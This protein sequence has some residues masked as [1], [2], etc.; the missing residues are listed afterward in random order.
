M[1]SLVLKNVTFSQVY[2][3]C[4]FVKSHKLGITTKLKGHNKVLATYLR[5]A[6]AAVIGHFK[7]CLP[8]D[9]CLVGILRWKRRVVI[10]ESAALRLALEYLKLSTEK[11]ICLYSSWDESELRPVLERMQGINEEINR[12]IATIITSI[13]NRDEVALIFADWLEERGDLFG[14]CIRLVIADRPEYSKRLVQL[15]RELGI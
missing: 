8:W 5:Y 15:W 10:F 11:Y 3:A 2:E 14:E 7:S 12:W 6:S 9:T 13:G 4:E 1:K